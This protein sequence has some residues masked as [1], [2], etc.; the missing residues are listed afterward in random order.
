MKVGRN[1]PRVHHALQV[2]AN[3]IIDEKKIRPHVGSTRL[4]LEKVE[5]IPERPVI[6]APEESGVKE[7]EKEEHWSE[8]NVSVND[9]FDKE[10]QASWILLFD[11][12]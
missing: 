5:L 3:V 8:P 6:K 12:G 7:N 9:C 10:S 1:E 4:T 11:I 2:A